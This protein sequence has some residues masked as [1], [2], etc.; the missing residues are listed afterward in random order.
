MNGF[1]ASLVWILFPVDTHTQVA[2]QRSDIYPSIPKVPSVY[3]HEVYCAAC[4]FVV[5]VLTAELSER[6][7]STHLRA[8]HGASSFQHNVHV[9][10]CTPMKTPRI[11]SLL[12]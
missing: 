7:K 11:N 3:I 12:A 1:D 4:L 6:M 5:D 10:I 8:E 2:L 9:S